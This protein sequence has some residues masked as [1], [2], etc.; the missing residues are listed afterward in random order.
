VQASAIGYKTHNQTGVAVNEDTTTSSNFSLEAAPASSGISYIYDKLGRLIAAVDLGGDT[1][2]YSYDEVG[3]LLSISRQPSSAVSIIEVTPSSGTI[4]TSVAIHGTGFSSTANQNTV[5]FNGISATVI[6]A[7]STQIITSVPAGATTGPIAVTS[8]AGSASSATPFIVNGSTP[9]PTITGFTPTTGLAGTPVTITGT[10]FETTAV[11][12]KVK[13]N[14]SYAVISTVSATSISTSVPTGATSGHVSV[15]TSY[16]KAVSAG[17]FFVPP[18]PYTPADVEVATRIAYGETKPITI[19]TATKI[20]LIVFDGVEGDRISLYLSGVTIVYSTI[21]LNRP[22]GVTQAATAVD[23]ASIG[24]IDVQLLPI[25][26]TYTIFVD[27]RDNY[28]GNM[29]LSL[30]SVADVTAAITTGGPSVNASIT[31]PGQN[32]LLTFSGTAGQKVSL[33]MTGVTIL[34]S[35]IVLKKPDGTNLAAT[36]VDSASS[37]FLETQL[38]PVNGTYT[39]FVD[40]RD[41]YTGNMTLTLYNVVDVTGTITIG[42]SPAIVNITTPGQKALLTF[43]GTSGQQVTVHITNNNIGELAVLLLKPDGTTLTS[44]VFCGGSFNLPTQTLPT[45]GTYTISI[46]PR[47]AY[48]GNVSVSVTS[49]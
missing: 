15:A 17:D 27:P 28:T 21:Y 10:N 26:G 39:I 23:N 32:A 13:F 12:N 31:I 40:P 25:T 33:K 22:D 34:Y 20:A 2:R 7:T 37:G 38:L 47:F 4:G 45:T 46:D 29:T 5:T 8:P 16:G 49:P 42:G 9:A 19:A 3:N 36:A 41:S 44:C 6:S 43:D 18:A 14:V 11:N 30:Y 24:L 1:A 35:T 48:I